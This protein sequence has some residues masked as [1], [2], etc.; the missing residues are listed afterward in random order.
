M[1]HRAT[2]NYGATPYPTCGT[3]LHGGA[4]NLTLS[5]TTLAYALRGTIRFLS[6]GTLAGVRSLGFRSRA[7]KLSSSCRITRRRGRPL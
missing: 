3:L 7:S 5:A 2:R 4:V 6:S 1:I